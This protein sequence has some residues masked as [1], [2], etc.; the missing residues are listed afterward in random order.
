[1]ESNAR[2][3]AL[4]AG[5][6]GALTLLAAL[7]AP[8]IGPASCAEY[9]RERAR[10]DAR[11]TGIGREE[12]RFLE[13]LFEFTRALA[14]ENAATVRWLLSGGRDGL[15]V[16]DHRVRLAGHQRELEQLE[17]PARLVPVCEFVAEAVRA[18]GAFFDD[19]SRALAE[20]R[21]FESQLTTEFGWNDE[22]GRS[23]RVL[24]RAY[25]QLLALYPQ[26]SEANRRAFYDELCALASL[27]GAAP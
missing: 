7:P 16:D 21:P 26:E 1:M 19:W 13:R 15:H 25:A 8:A 27:G 4:A 17:V 3:A 20:G 12:A 23:R 5:V 22:L 2:H 11:A 18:Q 14:A 24:L 6:A 10:F 9:G